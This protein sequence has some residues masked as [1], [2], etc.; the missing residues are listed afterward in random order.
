MN[1][2]YSDEA[3][4]L[5][6]EIR[7]LM[8]KAAEIAIELEFKDELDEEG[9]NFFSVSPEIGVTVAD[10][11]EI[12]EL[13][14]EYRGIDRETDVLSFPQFRGHNELLEDLKNT[15]SETLA[16]D[17]VICYDAA[18]RQASEYGTGLTRELLYLFVHSVLH[19]FGYD[20]IEEEDRKLMRAREESVL[21]RA[22]RGMRQEDRNALAGVT[23]KDGTDTKGKE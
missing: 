21:E 17:V 5:T 7:G 2:V 18:V 10:S 22:A 13:N 6:P 20:H 19:L 23:G 12:G 9:V 15:G 4:K 3:N 16:G 14:R 8:E 11:E 1:L